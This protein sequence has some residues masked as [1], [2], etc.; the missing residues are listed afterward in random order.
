MS[1]IS[2]GTVSAYKTPEEKNSYLQTDM[3]EVSCFF[4]FVFAFLSPTAKCTKLNSTSAPK[5]F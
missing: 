3:K 5:Y 2:R 1:L 4:Y